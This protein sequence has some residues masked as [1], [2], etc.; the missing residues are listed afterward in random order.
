MARTDVRKNLVGKIYGKL[1]VIEQ[2]GRNSSNKITWKCLCECGSN[3]IVSGNSLNTSK[4]KSCGC[5][6]VEGKHGKS[7]SSEYKT[8]NGVLQRCSNPENTQYENYGGRGITYDL[9]WNSF[10]EFYK[11]MGER[12]EGMTLDRI[13][14]NGDYCKDNC[15]W[16]ASSLQGFNKRKT[17]R[18]TSGY[19]GV[20]WDKSKEKWMSFIK[21]DNKFKFLG[22]FDDIESARQ[23]R[24]HAEL[25]YYGEVRSGGKDEVNL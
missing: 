9:R 21:K 13:D 3:C 6:K 11:D 7:Y 5:L 1:T 15:R 2:S 22:Y 16:A 20:H 23:C 24:E 18:N 10:E 8:W 19:V 17:K 14:V 12:P 4:T 25:K